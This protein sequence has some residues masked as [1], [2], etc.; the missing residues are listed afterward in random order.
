MTAPGVDVLAGYSPASVV[1]PGRLFEIVSGTSMSSPHVAGI[2]LLL[3][4]A[5]STWTPAMIKSALMTT[6]DNVVGT[7]AGDAGASA[8]ARRAFAQGAGHIDPTPAADPGLVYNNGPVD[9]LR[10]ICGTGQL[11]ASEC[12]PFGGPIDPSDLN[13]ASIAIGDL[14][15]TQ[16]VVPNG[17]ERFQ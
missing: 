4:D 17:D 10:F 16:T 8:D 2:G 12:A 7:F 1:V 6:A 3:K 14:A 5:H 11:P 13:L 9:W 15:G